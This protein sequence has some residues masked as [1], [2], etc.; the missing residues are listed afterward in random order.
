MTPAPGVVLILMPLKL[1]QAEQYEIINQLPQSKAIVL[2]GENSQKSV[3]S[4]VARGAYTHVFTSP[5]IV[6]SKKFKKCI[7]DQQTFT[8]RLCLLAIDEIH[9]VD[10]WG[11]SFRPMYAEIEKVRKRIP[12]HVPLLGVSAIIFVSTFSWLQCN[13]AFYNRHLLARERYKGRMLVS[14]VS[15]HPRASNHPIISHNPDTQSTYSP[16]ANG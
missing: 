14:C 12:C 5:E 16:T 11:K 13:I 2:N 8:D 4:G 15:N 7:L 3:F 1:L 9:L 6:L 10:E